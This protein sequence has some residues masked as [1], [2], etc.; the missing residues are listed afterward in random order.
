MAEIPVWTSRL[1]LP[2]FHR[3]HATIEC[4][5]IS[6]IERHSTAAGVAIP[7][8]L[9]GNGAEKVD[10]SEPR[11][12]REQVLA[13]L[14]DYPE[15]LTYREVAEKVNTRFGRE[16]KSSSMSW[17]L[18]HLKSDG[19]LVLEKGFWRLLA[20]QDQLNLIDPEKEETDQAAE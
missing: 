2:K 19:E 8:S 1:R 10:S 6:C 11:K 13:V 14:E 20:D 5:L 16:I 17:H 7:S 3:H 9:G 18:S 15:G 4:P 12:V